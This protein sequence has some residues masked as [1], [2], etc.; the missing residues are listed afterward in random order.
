V[1]NYIEKREYREETSLQGIKLL[2][3]S[4]ATCD[5]PENANNSSVCG[6]LGARK[7]RRQHGVKA[8]PQLNRSF[9]T[10]IQPTTNNAE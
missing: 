9:P 2:Q 8:G 5:F 4:N 7:G 1:S 10:V 3:S 6:G